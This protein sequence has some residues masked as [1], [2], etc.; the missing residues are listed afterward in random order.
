M[1]TSG[2]AS[3]RSGASPVLSLR[4]GYEAGWLRGDATAG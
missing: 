1:T 3:T 4:H 2:D